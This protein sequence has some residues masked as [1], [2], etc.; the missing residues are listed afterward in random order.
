MSSQLLRT[1]SITTK[2]FVVTSCKLFF[3]IVR[4]GI[5]L[6]IVFQGKI[7]RKIFI[8]YKVWITEWQ[9]KLLCGRPLAGN[10]GKNS[11][12]WQWR[13]FRKPN[14]DLAP[15]VETLVKLTATKNSL[16]QSHPRLVDPNRVRPCSIT[17]P[18]IIL[19]LLH[20]YLSKVKVQC[21]V[22]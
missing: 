14:N 13:T 22:A 6:Y 3:K 16:L 2:T 10:P 4:V 19:K 11:S 1:A 8:Q 5:V 17:V 21:S 20:I 18:Q 12:R 7:S 15:A 9:H